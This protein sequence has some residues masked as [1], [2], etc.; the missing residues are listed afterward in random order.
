MSN[1]QKTAI[2]QLMTELNELYPNLL[3]VYTAGGREFVNT[4]HKYL[5]VEKDQIVKAVNHTIENIQ[6]D[7][8][9]TGFIA[10]NGDGYFN[11]TY[12]GNK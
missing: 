7:E 2:Q 8:D 1:K 5:A 11:E 12:G 10:Q 4:C 3:N 6:L 9:K